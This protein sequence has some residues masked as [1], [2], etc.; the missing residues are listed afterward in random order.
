MSALTRGGAIE[1]EVQVS[2]DPA[3]DEGPSGSLLPPRLKLVDASLDLSEMAWQILEAVVPVFAEA[4]A[5]YALEELLT[6]GDPATQAP[7][8]ELLVRPARRG[9]HGRPDGIRSGLPAWTG[10]RL[11]R[12]VA[13]RDQR[14]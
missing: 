10:D 3:R 13:L 4:G 7:G 9:V 6:S 1:A 2:D 11:R 14:A 8:S 12:R 5:V